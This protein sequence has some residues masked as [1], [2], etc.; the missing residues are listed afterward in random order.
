MQGADFL[1][2]LK[3]IID[4]NRDRREIIL[5]TRQQIAIKKE[6]I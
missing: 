2:L 3:S 6:N 4:I 5:S 1:K